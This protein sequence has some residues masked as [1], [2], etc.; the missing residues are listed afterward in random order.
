MLGIKLRSILFIILLLILN[1]QLSSAFID[2]VDM[3]FMKYK[4]KVKGSNTLE[5]EELN[6]DLIKN[7]IIKVFK[8]NKLKYKIN[9]G[10][11]QTDWYDY[12][13]KASKLLI[14][15]MADDTKLRLQMQ[16]KKLEDQKLPFM[17]PYKVKKEIE[18]KLK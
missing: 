1:V 10:L 18:K 5:T 6:Y 2:V 12:K 8:S 14:T 4:N 15:I 9:S 16:Q 3:G 11:I 13:G 7:N 17:D